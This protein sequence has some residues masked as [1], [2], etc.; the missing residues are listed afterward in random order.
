L[1][2]AIAP[3]EK[4]IAPLEKA[5]APLERAIATPLEKALAALSQ[6][7]PPVKAENTPVELPTLTPPLEKE[8]ETS[9]ERQVREALQL[10]AEALDE[11]E[12]VT[13]RT[14][15]VKANDET[16]GNVEGKKV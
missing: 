1:E 11:A 5:I 3:L 12:G 7:T 6:A 8:K 10:A 13:K 4:A 2:K 16:N 14:S 15:K 9:L